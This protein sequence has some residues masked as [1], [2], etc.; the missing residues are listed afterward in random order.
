MVFKDMFRHLI[1]LLIGLSYALSVSVPTA[2]ARNVS[3]IRDAEI[4]TLL[5]EYAKPIL[6]AAKLENRGIEVILVNEL[7]FNAFVSGRRIFVNIGAILNAQTP[8]EIIGVLAHE[9]GHLAGRHQER[10]RAQLDRTKTLAIVGTLL[11][12]GAIVAG[13]ATGNGDAGGAA[14]GAIIGAAPQMAARSLLSYK[15]GEEINA[16]NAALQYLRTTKQSPKGMLTTFERFA[17]RLALA[18][19][20]PDPYLLSH[21]LP[22][23]RINLLERA[24]RKSPYFDRSDPKALQLRHDL[25]RAKIAAFSEGLPGLQRLFGSAPKSL[26]ALYGRAIALD[27]VG[28]SNDALKIMDALIKAQPANPYFYE[29]R[30][31]ILLKLRKVNDAVQAFVKATKLDRSGSGLI[32]ARLGFAYVATADQANA[33]KAISAVRKGIQA[34]PDNFNAYRTLSSAYA[35]SG[36]VAEAE[37]AMA[38][39]HFKAGNVRDAKIFAGRAVQKLV[40]GQ[41]SWQ[42][43][44]D[45]LLV[46]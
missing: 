2:Q 34:N 42:R 5:A 44:K 45:I 7:S 35:L 9:A 28:R 41:P 23:E 32:Q 33:K 38:E 13:S 37:L 14:G 3:I 19:V 16:D 18:G 46:K 8:N 21:P 4:E 6:Q 43:A 39:G 25:A 20:R 27:L 22:R 24:A 26:P 11:G 36:D 15:R 40:P 30:G 10:L 29:M 1:M 17:Q 31:E 12:V